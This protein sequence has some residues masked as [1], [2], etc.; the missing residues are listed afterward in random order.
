[1]WEAGGYC[2]IT[3]SADAFNATREYLDNTLILK[4]TFETPEG[5]ACVYDFFSVR[6]LDGRS[7][8]CQLIRIVEGVSGSLELDVNIS[9]RFAFGEIAPFI[10]CHDSGVYTAWGSNQGLAIYFQE[11]LTLRDNRDLYTR[12]QAQ[13]GQRYYLSIQFDLPERLG[14]C[15]SETLA[16]PEQLDQ[17]LGMCHAWWKD[18]LRH[19]KPECADDIPTL[20]SATILKGLIYEPTGAMIAAATTSLP[21]WIGDERN[22]DYRYSWIR[23]SVFA[24]RALD[25]LG[26]AREATR[27]GSFI[28]RSSAGSAEE[29][30]VV[31]GVDGKRRL[32]E[33]EL[34]WL[35]GY[36]RSQPVRVGNLAARQ[37]QLDMYGELM[38]LAWIRHQN[39]EEADPK[40]WDALV[41][42]VNLVCD[43]WQ[44]PD[45]G[46]WEVRNDPRHFVYSKAFCWAAIKRGIDFVNVCKEDAP[47]E[48]WCK[49]RDDIAA[50]IESHGYDQERGI[51]VQAFDNG[52]M[53]AAL[54]LL[55]RFHY[56]AYDDP[57]MVR[58]TDSTID[59]LR[60][61]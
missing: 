38:E 26:F 41:E 14:D 24:V 11:P 54:L 51:Y 29:V 57:R 39:G 22:W 56:L 6:T 35:E 48:R 53:D 18:W 31:Y 20:R 40:D 59:Q 9:P 2:A 50:A 16:Q 1:D 3:P 42:V 43:R 44:E 17:E 23:D 21:E 37:L 30:Q 7:D 27:F 34:D 10:R 25:E 28:E 33:I 4:T 45:Q 15:L 13:P 12:F 61:E 55:P 36:C 47:L 5:K 49:V 8:Y 32:P 60:S 46:I 52:H 58:T 19:L